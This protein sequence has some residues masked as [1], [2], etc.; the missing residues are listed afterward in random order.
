MDSWLMVP[1]GR[2]LL[3]NVDFK[4]VSLQFFSVGLGVWD[5]ES[6]FLKFF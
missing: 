6:V 1:K 3:N 4:A 2:Q 5:W